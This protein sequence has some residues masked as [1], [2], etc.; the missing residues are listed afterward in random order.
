[1]EEV[2]IVIDMQNDFVKGSLSTFE[3]KQ[4][5]PYI[6]KELENH[7]KIIFT[8]DTHDE[9]YLNTFEGKNLPIEHGIKNTYGHDIIEEFNDYLNKSIIVEKNSF[10]YI[11]WDELLKKHNL[12]KYPLKI[13][14]VCSDICVVS[15]SLIL[16]ALYND[17]E[18]TVLEKGCA[19]STKEKHNSAM[20]VLRSCQIKIE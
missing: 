16:R 10:G 11:K 17:L 6:L 15:N 1:M 20:D 8:K 9:N 3:A 7:D 12:N 5:I 13:V 14:G 19:G 18:I 2:L 4:T